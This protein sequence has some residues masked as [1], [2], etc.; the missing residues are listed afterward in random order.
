M[1]KDEIEKLKQKID[2][3]T[4]HLQS[5]AQPQNDK[6]NKS[7][8]IAIELV[9]GGVVGTAIGLFLDKIFDFKPLF[10]IICLMLGII[11]SFRNI[12][13]KMFNDI[14]NGS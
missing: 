8:T 6:L 10:L 13:R 9:A 1:S 12:W 5:R 7:S 3:A 2:K 11:A 14:E 4:K